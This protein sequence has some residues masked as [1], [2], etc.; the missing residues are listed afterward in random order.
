MKTDHAARR[1]RVAGALAGAIVLSG[2]VALFAKN[3]GAA[4]SPSGGG[5]VEGAP[6]IP[7]GTIIPVSLDDGLK[8]EDARKGDVVELRVKQEVPLRPGGKIAA[9]SKIVGYVASAERDSDGTGLNL[10]FRFDKLQYGDKT[11]QIVTSLRAMASYQAVRWSQMPQGGADAG[12]PA[13]WGT[14]VLIGGDIRFGDGGK[15]RTASKQFVG[16]GVRGGVLVHIRADP[17][18][19]CEGPVNGEDYPQALWVFS[20]GACGLYDLKGVTIKHN[21]TSDP[22]GE[23]TL[24]FDKERKKI[25]SG[26]GMLL[27]I[28]PSK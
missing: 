28:V 27:R 20:S 16:K 9:R 14:T 21:G 11:M 7:V 8:A 5:P 24:S 26:T 19:G 2:V 6:R 1:R 25:E 10:S 23:I 22:L 15:V 18:K 13:G 4:G 3:L 12:T 17:E